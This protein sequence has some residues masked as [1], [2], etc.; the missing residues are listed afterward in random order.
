MYTKGKGVLQDDKQ[1]YMWFN[2]ARY[3]HY[4]H[5]DTSKILVLMNKKMTSGNI[6]KAQ[7][8]SRI[9]LESNYTNCN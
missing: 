1:A 2:L 9:C 8:M 6:N 3:N 7:A 4:N 5:I